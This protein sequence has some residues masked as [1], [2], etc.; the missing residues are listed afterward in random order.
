MRI[1]RAIVKIEPVGVVTLLKHEIRWF[2]DNFIFW[3]HWQFICFVFI[4]HLW[5]TFFSCFIL[6]L[7]MPLFRG[8]LFHFLLN[9]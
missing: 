8:L 1:V 6:S 7:I 4:G 9:I 5:T 2:I 3:F